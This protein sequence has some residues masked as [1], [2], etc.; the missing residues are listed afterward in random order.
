MLFFPMQYV[1]HNSSTL[2]MSAFS[3]SVRKGSPLWIS[4]A[5]FFDA[6]DERSHVDTTWLI[7]ELRNY[8]IG[9]PN[10]SPLLPILWKIPFDL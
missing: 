2:F 5:S 1:S 7:T 3:S 6:G 4:N 10:L 8:F 9:I